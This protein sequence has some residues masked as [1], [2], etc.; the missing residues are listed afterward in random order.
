[1]PRLIN[2]LSPHLPLEMGILNRDFEPPE[3]HIADGHFIDNGI[4]PFDQQHL[5]VRRVA[6]DLDQRLIGDLGIGHNKRQR[7]CCLFEG[8]RQAPS[9]SADAD[10]SV[11]RKV[12][13]SGG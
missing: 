5:Y 3:N 1:M 6:G 7:V 2:R 8:L 9:Q 10:I 12:L 11:M 13:P 4:E